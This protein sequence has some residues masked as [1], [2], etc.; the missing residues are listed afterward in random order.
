MSNALAIAGSAESPISSRALSVAG[1]AH[2]RRTASLLLAPA[3]WLALGGAADSSTLEIG[4]EGLRSQRG[5]V[6]ICL[7]SNPAHFPR[8]QGDPQAHRINV[9]VAQA[10]GLRF[11][12]M[13]PGAYAISAMHD[14]NGNGRLDAFMGI[15]REGFGFSRNPRVT[16]GAP[17][18]EQVRFQITPGGNSQ[19]I[20]FQ[21]FV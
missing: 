3:A 8:C 1:S 14:E 17:R 7:T 5:I 15:P 16:F 9:P 4:V 10:R 2:L 12:N 6:R 21:Y 20:R 13:A 11:G 18:F 19:R